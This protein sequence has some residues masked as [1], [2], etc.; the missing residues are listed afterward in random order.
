MAHHCRRVEIE[1]KREQRGGLQENR[2]EPLRGRVMANEEKKMVA[3]SMRR[4]TQQL[5]KCW[6]C[7][8]GGHRLWMCS[9]KAAHPAKGEAQ[10]RKLKCGKCG[11]ENHVAKGCKNYWR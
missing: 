5:V 4:E 7:R 1:V 3:C 10:Q 11:E 2:W 8:E 9:K 6:G